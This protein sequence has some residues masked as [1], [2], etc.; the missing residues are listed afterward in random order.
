MGNMVQKD[1]K[2]CCT[3][4]NLASA[5]KLQLL[6]HNFQALC[7][8]VGICTIAHPLPC[9]TGDLT[10]ITMETGFALGFSVC[11]GPFVSEL[12]LTSTY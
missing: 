7:D 6:F 5:I 10:S 9:A 3:P 11:T 4:V 12:T 1:T 8:P 2:K